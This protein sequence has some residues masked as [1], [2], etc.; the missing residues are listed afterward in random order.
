MR[1]YSKVLFVF[2]AITLLFNSCKN[3]LKI[4]APYKESISV[5]A[6]LNAQDSLN[7]VRINK[8]FL[9][10]GNAYVM[11]TVEDSVNYRKG[12]L[13]VTLER[14][15]YG[16]PASTSVGQPG[17][18]KIILRDTL[19]TLAA[20]AFNQNQRLWYT[21]DKLYTDGDYILTIKNNQT[22]NVFTSK[23]N[24]VDKA[25]PTFKQPLAGPYFPVTSTCVPNC[26]ASYYQDL[27]V[28][29]LKRNIEFSSKPGCRKYELTARFH[30]IDSTTSGNIS[31]YIDFPLPS[32]STQGLAGNEIL[33]VSW[34]SGQLFSHLYAKLINNEPPNFRGRRMIKIDYIVTGGNQSFVD[35]LNVNAPSN[36]VAQDKPTYTNI[37]GGFG[38]FGCRSTLHVS[39]EFHN[40]TINYLSKNKPYCDLKFEDASGVVPGVC[41]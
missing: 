40:N 8:V 22:G 11:A 15:Y 7:Y 19:F 4:L 18:M 36:T 25:S 29:T 17:K 12:V 16:T 9:G 41:F 34:Y 38:I 27:S 33:E 1:F 10:E 24:M 28:E 2:A 32:V 13:D 39:K 30:Y 14:T 23:T 21:N 3:D 37:E 20:G 31:K 35:F 26:P 6:V 5:Y